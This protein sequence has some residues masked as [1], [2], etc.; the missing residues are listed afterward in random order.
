MNRMTALPRKLTGFEVDEGIYAALQVLAAS[1]EDHKL[2][3]AKL[4][5]PENLRKAQI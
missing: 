5:Q 2:I 4:K 1:Y 3:K